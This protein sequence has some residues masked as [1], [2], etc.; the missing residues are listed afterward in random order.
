MLAPVKPP[1][2]NARSP[3]IVPTPS[4]KVKSLA[5]IL[6]STMIEHIRSKVIE[7]STSQAVEYEIVILVAPSLIIAAAKI[8]PRT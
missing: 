5:S 4:A 3:T 8:P 7:I 1:K 6:T 2:M